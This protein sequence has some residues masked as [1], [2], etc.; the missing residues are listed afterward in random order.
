VYRNGSYLF[1]AGM[2]RPQ[3]KDVMVRAAQEIAAQLIA[4]PVSAD[5]LRR[6]TG[7]AAEQI[8]R[9]SSGNVFWM[10]QTEGATRDPRHF[11]AL[12]SYLTDLTRV[13]PQQLQTLAIRYL[14]PNRAI[15]VLILP[16]A[17]GNAAQPG[18]AAAH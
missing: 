4:Q 7:P 9:A 1:V 2:V 17:E 10:Y 16:D 3:D 13:T 14:Q 8:V 15:P 5:E 6:A 11:A 12:R 18:T